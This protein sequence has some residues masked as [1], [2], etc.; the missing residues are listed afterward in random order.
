MTAQANAENSQRIIDDCWNAGDV[1]VIDQLVSADY[2]DH[3]LSTHEELRGP[4]A[5]KERID[6]YRK[7]MPDLHVTVEDLLASDDEV[8]ARWRC[9]ATNDGEFLGNPPT[10]RH[11]DFTGISID[12]FDANGRLVESWDQWDNLS[13]LQQLELA[14]AQQ[15]R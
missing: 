8:V 9:T 10:H 5:N 3:D 13:L 12:R 2:I 11:V 15:A 7:A 4:K 14:P 6:S 1:Q